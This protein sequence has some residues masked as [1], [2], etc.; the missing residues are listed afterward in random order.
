MGQAIVDV[1][2]AYPKYLKQLDM[3]ANQF[4][5]GA[6]KLCIT[7]DLA[8][9]TGIEGLTVR[10]KGTDKWKMVNLS[11]DQGTHDEGMKCGGKFRDRLIR[12]RAAQ[13]LANE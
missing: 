12:Q 5:T 13:A 1:D 9:M 7:R 11:P 3:Q 8:E 2:V 4:S 10:F 6:I